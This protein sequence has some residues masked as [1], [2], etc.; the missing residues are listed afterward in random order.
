M[1]VLLSFKLLFID[2]FL[3][4]KEILFFQLSLRE[5]VIKDGQQ[6]ETLNKLLAFLFNY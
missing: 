1:S 4:T 6:P 5:K 2:T 3:K